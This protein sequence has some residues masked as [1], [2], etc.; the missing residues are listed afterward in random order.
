M[1]RRPK[2]TAFEYG[3]VAALVA[4]A[5]IGAITAVGKK[6]DPLDAPYA[7][8]NDLKTPP[9]PFGTRPRWPVDTAVLSDNI[10]YVRKGDKCYA[11]DFNPA[12][13]VI[14]TLD[15]GERELR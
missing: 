14:N 2:A 6:V 12:Q 10:A 8:P 5:L 9:H 11:V 3:L 15:C 1:S 4:I 7:T 13:P